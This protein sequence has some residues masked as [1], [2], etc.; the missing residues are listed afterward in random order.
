MEDMIDDFITFFVAGQ[1][2]TA[3]T[4]AFCFIEIAKHPL[5]AKKLREEIDSV[6][7]D[8]NEITNEDLTKLKYVSSVIKETLRLW[9]PAEGPVREVDVDNFEIN[10]I[11][12]PN[13]SII[14]SNNYLNARVESNFSDP[15]LF[16]PERF[17]TKDSRF[18]SFLKFF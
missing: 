14:A 11:N 13:G 12:I 9:G 15:Y 8:R 4:L 3:N 18:Y 1:E 2:T 10:G 17:M 16:N 5:V 7:G 6:L